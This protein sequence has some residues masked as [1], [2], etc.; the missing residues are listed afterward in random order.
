[1][2]PNKT[3]SLG[4]LFASKLFETQVHVRRLQKDM[5]VCQALRGSIKNVTH[6]QRCPES[7][8]LIFC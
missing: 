1:L 4:V 2:D 7:E 8:R 6:A 5:G 3:P